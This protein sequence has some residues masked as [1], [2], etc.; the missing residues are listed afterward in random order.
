MIDGFYT[1]CLRKCKSTAFLIFA[2]PILIC[3]QNLS[4]RFFSSGYEIVVDVLP[5]NDIFYSH[6]YD[7]GI[8]IYNLAEVFQVEP[9]K[10]LRINKF[11]PTQPNNDGKIVKIPVKKDLLI[12]NPAEKK[13]SGQYLPVYYTVKKGESLYRIS[14]QYFDTDVSTLLLLNNKE[15]QDIKTGEKL[16][17]AWLP[18]IKPKK[19]EPLKNP[20][21]PVK[22]NAKSNNTQEI[23]AIEPKNEPKE[24]L[25]ADD[26]VTIVKYY[27]SDVIGMWDRSSMESKSYFVLH[28]EARPG[29]M[30]DVYNPMLKKHIKAKVLGKI[31]TGTYH[32]DITIIIS[33]AIAKDLGILD[34]RFKVNIKFEK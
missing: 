1:V 21:Y 14:K 10:V 18:V 33:S 6:T 29:T 23:L 26:H 8:S 11:N 20:V 27:L 30:M 3:G 25:S 16:L 19:T 4:N 7:K 5:G 22:P 31:P 34:V 32:D 12:T 24:K 13:K 15:G 17:I 28:D 2:I 9:E